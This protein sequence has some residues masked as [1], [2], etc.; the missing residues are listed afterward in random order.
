MTITIYDYA[1]KPL[2]LELP[3]K[4]IKYI[5]VTVLSGDETGTVYFEDGSRVNFD[6]SDCRIQGFYD[7]SY[8]VNGENI[9]KWINFNNWDGY[10]KS[11][12]R[13]EMFEYADD[14]WED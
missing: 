6:A 10:T 11:Y 3:D 2:E 14:D 7:G 9:E 5:S 12:C 4:K 1:D 8:I 13:Q